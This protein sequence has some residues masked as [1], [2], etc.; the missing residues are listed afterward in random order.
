L[1]QRSW[2]SKFYATI[3][4]ISHAK[5]HAALLG[6]RVLIIQSDPN[7]EKFYRAAGGILAG[8]QE[9]KSIPGR[10]LPTLKILLA[11]ETTD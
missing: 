5:S 8:K 3:G 4:L 1:Q 2:I 10:L 6:G 11:D 7:A 9:S